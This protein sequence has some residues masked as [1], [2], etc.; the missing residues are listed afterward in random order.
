[1]KAGHTT[2]AEVF[3]LRPQSPHS[4]PRIDPKRD[5]R[6]VLSSGGYKPPLRLLPLLLSV[7][8]AAHAGDV[9]TLKNGRTADCRILSFSPTTVKILWQEK[10]ERDIPVAD[11]EFIDFAPLPGEA[12]AL[13]KAVGDGAS[14]PLMEFWVKKIPRLPVARSNGGE[15]GLTYAELLSR[16]ATP[17]RLA[18]ALTVYQQIESADWSAERRGRARAGRLRLML[19]QGRAEEVKPE[20]EKLLKESEDARVLIELQHVL[21]ETAAAKLRALLK[22]HPR[23]EQEDDIRPQRDRLFHEALDAYLFPHA[24]HGAEEDLAAR[25]LWAA[26]QF[27]KENGDPDAA[28][29]AASDLLQLYPSAAEKSAAEKLLEQ[30][31]A[32]KKPGL[33]ADGPDI[34]AEVEP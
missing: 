20:A 33:P 3:N 28:R 13:A 4:A 31:P 32:A 6:P 30:I 23:W 5:L 10:E 21:A 27:Y 18:R 15:I 16:N 12:A 29:E 2:V 9:L 14:E 7:L 22:E 26:A 24:F 11:I 8:S 19:R 34:P 1:M 25:G 17:D